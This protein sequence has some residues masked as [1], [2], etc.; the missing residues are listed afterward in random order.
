M[1]ILDEVAVF[2]H[3]GTSTVMG[4]TNAHDEMEM[5]QQA[6]PLAEPMD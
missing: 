3:K 2:A 1:L 6:S 4:L 5:G